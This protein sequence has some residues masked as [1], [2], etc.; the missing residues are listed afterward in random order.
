[1]FSSDN[2]GWQIKTSLFF[3][4]QIQFYFF[5][6]LLSLN[7]VDGWNWR[8]NRMYSQLRSVYGV[9]WGWDGQTTQSRR[10]TTSSAS[11]LPAAYYWETRR[12][13]GAVLELRA[14]LPGFPSF[15]PLRDHRDPWEKY[16]DSWTWT[17][18]LAPLSRMV[19]KK[20]W[21]S[22]WGMVYTFYTL[23]FERS[24]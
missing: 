15:H 19:E 22:S 24:S 23:Y 8:S 20:F 12:K 5:V 2:H 14:R 1:M 18:S 7:R 6:L 21:N 10:R 17:D 9:G 3:G 16:Q 11:A 13:L 4:A